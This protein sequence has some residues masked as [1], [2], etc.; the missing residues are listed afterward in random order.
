MFTL[1]ELLG[2]LDRLYELIQS[3]LSRMQKQFL[4]FTLPPQP[5][6]FRW[7]DAYDD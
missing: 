4:E 2:V 3:S 1:K 6:L 5:Y 7:G